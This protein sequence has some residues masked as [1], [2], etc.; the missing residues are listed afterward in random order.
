MSLRDAYKNESAAQLDDLPDRGRQ[1]GPQGVPREAQAELAGEVAMPAVD[2]R[3]PC[4]IGVGQQTWHPD[5]VGDEGAPEP[6]AM[7]EDVARVAADDTGVAS[8]AVLDRLDSLQIVYCQTWQYDD[9]T[10]RLAAR[11]GVEPRHT[12]Y[13]GIG[14]TTPQVLVNGAAEQ[15]L[16]GE[17][18]VALICGAEALATQRR[19]KRRGERYPYSFKPEE[20]RPFPWEAPFHPAEVAHE[21]FQAWLTFADLR[22]RP[23]RP[24]GCR[25]RRVP[26]AAGRA[27]G[28]VHRRRRRQPARVVPG[29]PV[30]RGDHHGHA[31]EPHG[32]L[33]VHE[34]H[35]LDHGRRHGRGRARRQPRGRRRPRR[36]AGAPRLPARLVL[37]DGP[38]L[39]R[40]ARRDVAFAGDG[41]GRGRGV[42]RRGRRCRRRRPPR[43]VQLLRELGELRPRRA[44]AA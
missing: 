14:G 28:A 6:L 26:P 30:G 5:E 4:L 11:L 32:R 34:V 2:P 20:R 35:D 9:P 31:R 41:G 16:A 33:P 29:G 8:S 22:Q 21:V 43:R 40:R 13:S 44:G 24:P 12:Y 7:W 27:A 42:A 1:G 19:Y 23:A 18:D 17:L 15:V 25:S 37:R 39:P 38:G 3:T 10:A 36:A